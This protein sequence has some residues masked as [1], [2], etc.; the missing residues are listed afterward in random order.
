M[1]ARWTETK[2]YFK[3]NFNLYVFN[4]VHHLSTTTPKVLW[5]K[6]KLFLFETAFL[7]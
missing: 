4:F 3:L 7:H 1:V 5:P 2:L 6:L